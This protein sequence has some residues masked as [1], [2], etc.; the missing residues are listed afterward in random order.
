MINELSL[1]KEQFENEDKSKKFDS[2]IKAYNEKGLFPFSLEKPTINFTTNISSP[3][4]NINNKQ[5]FEFSSLKKDFS[6]NNFNAFSGNKLPDFIYE[7]PHPNLLE[8]SEQ[9]DYFEYQNNLKKEILNKMSTQDYSSAISLINKFISTSKEFNQEENPLHIEM[10]YTLAEC[11]LNL[12]NLEESKDILNEIILLTENINE[13]NPNNEYLNQNLIFNQK[14]NMLLGAISLN[15]GEYNTALKSYF[16][17]ENNLPKICKEPELNVKLS[18]VYLNIGLCYIYL[19][20]KNIAEK[21]LKKGLSQ[22]EG[23]LNNNTI[24]KLNADIFE[25]LG[26]IYEMMN[27]YK[28]SLI[29]YKKSLKLKFNLYGEAHDEVLE[30]QYKISQV[31]LSMKQFQQADEILSSI[32]ELIL[33]QKIHKATQETIYRYS[34]YFY[35]Y[36]IVLIKLNKIANAKNYFNKVLEIVDGFLLPNDPWIANINDLIKICDSKKIK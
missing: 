19:G 26:V 3:F 14:A 5:K 10:L 30:L 28:D 4:K 7:F 20:N 9:K 6:L 31:F 17:C 35:T 27:R 24:H 36:G 11:H 22:T 15:L 23:I 13:N 12:T 16:S 18:A 1:N 8:S 21:Y 33:N 2:L 32:V 29:F 25:N 34:T